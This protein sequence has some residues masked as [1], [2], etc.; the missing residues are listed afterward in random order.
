MN[1]VS[2]IFFISA[3]VFSAAQFVVGQFTCHPSLLLIIGYLININDKI[4]KNQN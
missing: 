4:S 2:K 1:P 3:V